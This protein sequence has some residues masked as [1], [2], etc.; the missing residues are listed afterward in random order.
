VDRHRRY[1]SHACR[2]VAYRRSKGK[3]L[4]RGLVRL[5][6]ADDRDFPPSLPDESAGLILT[7]LGAKMKPSRSYPP[8]MLGG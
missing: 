7:G 2:H 3:G 6:E 4:K 1:C 5:M 8:N